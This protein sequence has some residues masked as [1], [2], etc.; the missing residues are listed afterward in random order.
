MSPSAAR[1]MVRDAVLDDRFNKQPS[2]RNSCVRID[3]NEGYHVDMPIYR[4]RNYDG[5]YELAQSDNWTVSRAAD[6]ENWFNSEN[7]RLSPDTDNGRQFRRI[8]R[9]LKKFARSRKSWKS[10]IASG[11]TITKLASEC[12]VNNLEREDSALR[13][14]MACMYMRLCTSL[15][16]IHPVT[17]DS[18]L[19]KGPNDASTTFLRDRLKEAIDNLTVL[20]NSNCTRQQALSAWDTVFNTSFFSNRL[21]STDAKT[22]ILQSSLK[23]A[24][25]ATSL[26]FPDHPIKPNKPA[27]FA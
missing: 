19:T 7:Q 20:E 4:I 17:H 27:G 22:S 13:D 23:P 25:T 3:Y 12:F 14:T 2:V 26:T 9:D 24:A 16:V 1:K 21:G 5:E 10:K 6:V 15:E 8:V 11:F 18:K